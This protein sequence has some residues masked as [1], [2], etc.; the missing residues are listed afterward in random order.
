MKITRKK[1][2]MKI[3]MKQRHL[4]HPKIRSKKSTSSLS[5]KEIQWTLLL[6]R[7]QWLNLLRFSR[8]LKLWHLFKI[9]NNLIIM[10]MVH[11][12]NSKM[13]IKNKIMNFN[14]LYQKMFLIQKTM[15][16]RKLTIPKKCKRTNCKR[17]YSRC[18]A[19]CQSTHQNSS[20]HIIF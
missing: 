11:F 10:E 5:K 7:R 19:N 18:R 13:H 2:K 1:F 4:L 17:S 20:K 6:M 14:C 8:T 12:L 16:F 3:V 15:W 9:K